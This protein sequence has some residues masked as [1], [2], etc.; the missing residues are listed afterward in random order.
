MLSFADR[1]NA[2][3]LVS[4]GDVMCKWPVPGERA[5]LHIEWSLLWIII[6]FNAIASRWDVASFKCA[7]VLNMQSENLIKTA[8]SLSFESLKL[9]E[10][11]M[12]FVQVASSLYNWKFD[13]RLMSLVDGWCFRHFFFVRLL[14]GSLRRNQ[15]ECKR[16]WHSCVHFF[17]HS[18]AHFSL[19]RFEWILN[20]HDEKHM[21]TK[22]L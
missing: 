13:V 18:F 15:L 14:W 2:Q 20:E 5:R 19:F 17:F 4:W 21:H 22:S 16:R 6:Y 8:F 1:Y 9:F 7:N 12:V 11:S 10:Y 3:L